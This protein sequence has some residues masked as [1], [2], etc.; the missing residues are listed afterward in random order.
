VRS[1]EHE[2]TE[3][4]T[5]VGRMTW[6]TAQR[7][8]QDGWETT[9][10]RQWPDDAQYSEDSTSTADDVSVDRMNDRD[11]PATKQRSNITSSSSS[12]PFIQGC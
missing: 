9:E 1:G 4:D 2:Y 11:V 12:Y 3:L 5:G 6:R 8:E 7:V 10:Q